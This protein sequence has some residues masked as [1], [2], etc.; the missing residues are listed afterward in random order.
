MKRLLLTLLIILTSS[1]AYSL[2]SYKV[3][4]DYEIQASMITTDKGWKV[5]IKIRDMLQKKYIKA[6]SETAVAPEDIDLTG[7]RDLGA[8][9]HEYGESFGCNIVG[10]SIGTC[11]YKRAYKA[12]TYSVFKIAMKMQDAG[13]I[14]IIRYGSIDQISTTGVMYHSTKIQPTGNYRKIIYTKKYIP[15]YSI[16]TGISPVMSDDNLSVES[17]I[18]TFEVTEYASARSNTIWT[19]SESHILNFDLTEPETHT[20][21]KF[22]IPSATW[23]DAQK[24]MFV[25]S[26]LLMSR[27]INKNPEILLEVKFSPIE[28]TN[29]DNVKLINLADGILPD[30][31]MVDYVS[32]LPSIPQIVLP[33]GGATL[34]SP[35]TFSWQTAANST[36]YKLEYWE[37]GKTHKF[38]TTQSTSVQIAMPPG[39]Y[40]WN[41]AGVNND[42]EGE[43]SSSY[44]T[45]EATKYIRIRNT[46]QS[47]MTGFPYAFCIYE[48]RFYTGSNYAGTEF[49]LKGTATASSDEPGY[50]ASKTLDGFTGTA[51]WASDY[52]TPD[53]W[54][55]I[56]QTAQTELRVLRS[57]KLYVHADG[58]GA[59]IGKTFVVE[60]SHNADYSDSVVLGSYSV[61]ANFFTPTWL[62]FVIQ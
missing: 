43:Y 56:S 8:F 57:F 51:W 9:N 52:N 48:I 17:W 3:S 59:A 58:T 15:D 61:T 6:W 38:A 18:T 19:E 5:N 7:N 60:A 20:K 45:A 49:A 33:T 47:W 41:I 2:V 21:S 37:N 23:L 53:Q 35:V 4:P 16:Y 28:F 55:G 40:H 27:M 11:N 46:S 1:P 44:F 24:A 10:E 29:K 32:T 39:E 36:S 30:G 12:I 25:Q 50:E 14:P 62:N 34:K 42:G 22:I 31:T 13:F 54:I 26:H